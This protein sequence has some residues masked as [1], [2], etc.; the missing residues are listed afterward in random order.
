MFFSKDDRWVNITQLGGTA[1]TMGLHIVSAT[2]VGLTFGYF[3]DKYFGTRPWLIMIFFFL[4]IIA[5]F[6]MVFEDFRRLQRREEAK[7]AGSL[8]QDGEKSAGQ[9]EPRA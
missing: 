5:G 3:L 6:K 9:D 1:G 8:K 4:G 7:R 2:V